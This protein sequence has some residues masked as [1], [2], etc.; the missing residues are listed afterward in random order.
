MSIL[1]KTAKAIYPPILGFFTLYMII[2]GLYMTYQKKTPI[3]SLFLPKG[4]WTSFRGLHR[5]LSSILWL[6]FTVTV[7]TGAIYRMLKT[8]FSLEK[9]SVS[10]L[11]SWHQGKF[12]S[13]LGI[14]Y[15]YPIL[16]G[17][18]AL[19]AMSAGVTM[20]KNIMGISK[21]TEDYMYTLPGGDKKRPSI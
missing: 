13:G 16:I 20:N 9:D 5:N 2:S 11:L 8:W 7:C 18:L 12:V 17:V 19:A 21:P 3:S 6:P 10:F 1:G 15:F 4:K 14:E